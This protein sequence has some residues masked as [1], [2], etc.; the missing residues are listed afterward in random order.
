MHVFMW[1]FRFGSSFHCLALAS[2]I[3]QKVQQLLHVPFL[4]FRSQEERE[5]SSLN[6][7][8]KSLSLHMIFTPYT[9]NGQVLNEKIKISN[10]NISLLSV[11][12][13]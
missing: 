8:L 4:S 11:S 3:L 9:P 5:Q 13:L 6:L 1:S 12:E 10:G 2:V 7:T